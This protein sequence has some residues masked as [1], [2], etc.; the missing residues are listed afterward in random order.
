MSSCPDD[1]A[2]HEKTD[3]MEA[4][5]VV[6]MAC[7]YPDD[8]TSPSAF[9][10]MLVNA[11]SAWSEVPENRYNLDAYWHPNKERIGTTTSRGA[12]WMKEDPACFDAPVAKHELSFSV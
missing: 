5:A 1:T 11:R 6:G 4:V 9:F 12:H 10:E 3:K 8:A 7:R 2:T